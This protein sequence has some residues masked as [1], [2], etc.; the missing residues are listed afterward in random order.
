MWLETILERKI[1]THVVENTEPF[2]GCC[3]EAG[4]CVGVWDVGSDASL[5]KTPAH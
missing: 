4:F 2:Y 1:V 5:L 3:G